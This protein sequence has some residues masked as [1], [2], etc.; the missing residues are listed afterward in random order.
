MV[1]AA[2]LLHQSSRSWQSA[3][4][5][6][7]AGALHEAETLLKDA[8]A[9]CHSLL[10]DKVQLQPALT[11]AQHAEASTLLLRIDLALARHVAL[12]GHG[13]QALSAA[14]NAIEQHLQKMRSTHLDAAVQF[15]ACIVRAE[16]HFA[17]A[18][19]DKQQWRDA[20]KW[21][22]TAQL[23]L[24]KYK[25]RK[26]EGMESQLIPLQQRMQAEGQNHSLPAGVRRSSTG[27]LGA[28]C[29]SATQAAV[30]LV[31][32]GMDR[33]TQD[34]S[35]EKWR[36]RVVVA[37]SVAFISS[38]V[39]VAISLVLR[40]DIQVIIPEV[41][42]GFA[43][44]ILGWMLYARRAKRRILGERVSQV[45]DC[46]SQSRRYLS[47]VYAG[48]CLVDALQWAAC[49]VITEA[50]RIRNR[51]SVSNEN[52]FETQIMM[53]LSVCLN[54]VLIAP[55][56]AIVA[57]VVVKWTA[58]PESRTLLG[59]HP[60]SDLSISHGSDRCLLSTL[61]GAESEQCDRFVDEFERR[62]EHIA[63]YNDFSEW[64]SMPGRSAPGES[65]GGTVKPGQKESTNSMNSN[66]SEAPSFPAAPL[67]Q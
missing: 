9:T 62:M 15:D 14:G 16:A 11:R 29:A 46:R 38:L 67:V 60:G 44:F 10:D 57:I 36:R 19:S 52:T 42:E 4:T 32:N 18:Q 2:S 37:L 30:Q 34:P 64:W 8:S 26:L 28:S 39:T 48:W 65:K 3:L 63:F 55:Y 17:L 20:V 13:S 54:A 21:T 23:I 51:H 49:A 53:D 43:I 27:S 40:W 6:L 1:K 5:N 61:S 41:V 24:T 66:D 45:M 31:P 59:S 58:E 22:K 33:Y 35:R 12:S 47:F 25:G 7:A 56:R 50:F